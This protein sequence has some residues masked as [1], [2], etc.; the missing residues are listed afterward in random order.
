MK[1]WAAK[2]PNEVVDR[3]ISWAPALEEGETVLTSD[4]I[5]VSGTV[6]IDSDTLAT[7]V[8]TAWLSGGTSGETCVLTNRVTTSGGRTYDQSVRIRIKDK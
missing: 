1:T 7:P 6:V 8:A 3:F 5:L 4:F 2:D